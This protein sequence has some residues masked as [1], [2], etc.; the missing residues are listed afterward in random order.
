MI[1]QRHLGD[2]SHGRGSH[3]D[4]HQWM[5]EASNGVSPGGDDG[6]ALRCEDLHRRQPCR[7]DR[8]PL[9]GQRLAAHGAGSSP[10]GEPVVCRH[11]TN[12]RNGQGSAV[13]EPNFALAGR[14]GKRRR[15]AN[16]AVAVGGL[17]VAVGGP[18]RLHGELLGGERPWSRPCSCRRPARPWPQRP[19]GPGTGP[20]P[21]TDRPRP[22]DPQPAGRPAHISTTATKLLMLLRRAVGGNG[23]GQIRQ[24]GGADRVRRGRT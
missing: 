18:R 7:G 5:R 6:L 10:L 1:G 2:G 20:C 13:R 22:I 4:A 9:A 3:R 14:L 15:A 17:E 8:Q 19:R 21:R 23:S 11:R 12:Q 24:V 16:P